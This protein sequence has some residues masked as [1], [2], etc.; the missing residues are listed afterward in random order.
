MSLISYI[1][2]IKNQFYL[3]VLSFSIM[4][5]FLFTDLAP[6]GSD[7]WAYDEGIQYSFTFELRDKGRYGFA[8]PESQIKATCEETTIAVKYIAER[9]LNYQY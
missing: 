3:P 4:Y 2:F 7:D 6:G 9:I 8:L 1:K 5:S